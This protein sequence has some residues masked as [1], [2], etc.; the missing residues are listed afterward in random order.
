MRA[1][2]TTA[3]QKVPAMG[4]VP[5]AGSL[6][7]Y[8]H[9]INQLPILDAEEEYDLAV[10]YRKENNLEAAQKLVT[11]NLRFV[12]NIAK[13]YSGYGLALPDLIQ[14]G[15][16]GLMKAVK[17]FDPSKGV[18]LISFAVYWIRAEIHEFI[19]KNWRLVKVATTK[20]QRKL[21][22]K[23][24][25]MKKS[26]SWLKKDEI[27]EIA[28]QLD[29]K[30][31]EISEMEQRMTGKDIHFDPA[32]QDEEERDYV[33]ALYL[34]SKEDSPEQAAEESEWS[35]HCR[36]LFNQAL[37]KLDQRS[38]EIIRA[39]WLND[40]SKKTTLQEL[41]ERYQVSAER[42]RQIENQAIKQIKAEISDK[43]H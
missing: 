13:K 10:K 22:F 14:E 38:L 16:V 9:A 5:A 18:R 36:R 17:H 20:A 2:E 15:N 28:E 7:A 19:I 40:A 39:R 26:L 23:L 12:V 31:E 24:R 37:E 21:F 27:D 30:P 34:A 3:L 41:A 4:L 8:I 42:I 6:N 11:H 35:E 29:V 33:P 1:A 25:S 32:E 43:T